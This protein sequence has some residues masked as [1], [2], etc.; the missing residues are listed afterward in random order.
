MPG[1][2]RLIPAAAYAKILSRGLEMNQTTVAS[3]DFLKK[4]ARAIRR[5]IVDNDHVEVERGLLRQRAIDRVFYR[6]L[7]IANRDH[8]ACSN[9]EVLL[10]LRGSAKRGYEVSSETFQMLACDPLHL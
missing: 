2:D 6:P 7:A 8:Y 5:M 3:C 1:I 9:R 4:R 10:A